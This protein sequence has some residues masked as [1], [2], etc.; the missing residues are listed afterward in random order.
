MEAKNVLQKQ[1]CSAFRNLSGFKG[2]EREYGMQKWRSRVCGREY[3]TRLYRLLI[4]QPKHGRIN[5]RSE[6]KGENKKGLQKVA[7]RFAEA[8]KS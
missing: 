1:I 8:M 2:L 6:R 5:R 4:Y 3:K 7:K